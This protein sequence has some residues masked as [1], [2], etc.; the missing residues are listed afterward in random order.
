MP[1]EF[2]GQRSLVG[3]S[4]WD[5]KELDR[6]EATW[7]SWH[8]QKQKSLWIA[9]VV[10]RKK[11]KAGR[12]R[13]TDFKLY[14]EATRRI[15][16]V[17]AWVSPVAQLVKNPPVMQEAPVWFPWRKN[18]LLTPVSVGF[19]GGSD[20]K[21]STLS[22]EDLCFPWVGK[23]PLEEVMATHS[24][25]LPWRIPKDRGALWAAVHEVTKCWIRPSD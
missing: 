19:P 15:S 22:V 1:G 18:R 5:W 11:N 8:V 23:I 24:T 3:Y 20:D 9:N 13:L 2:H 17:Q 16:Y 12:I 6:I 21:E 25:I 4:P 7:H 14:Y 10:L